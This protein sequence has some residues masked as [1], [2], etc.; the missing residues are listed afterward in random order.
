MGLQGRAI[1]LRFSTL[2]RTRMSLGDDS[3]YPQS[4]RLT[5]DPMVLICT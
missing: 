2:V 5:P 3:A 4:V 1:A